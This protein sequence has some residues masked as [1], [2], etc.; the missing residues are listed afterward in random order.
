MLVPASPLRFFS[1]HTRRHTRSTAGAPPRESGADRHA[2]AHER[3]TA[4]RRLATSALA[5]RATW[6]TLTAAVLATTVLATPGNCYAEEDS[7]PS[8]LGYALEGF[9]TGIAVGFASGYLA[10]GPKFEGGEWRTLLWGGGIGALSGLGIGLILGI[11]DASTVPNGRGVGFYI[12]R[13]SNYG[14]SVGALAGGVI[15]ALIWAGGGVA[16]DLLLGLAW[17]TV[18]GAGAG[19]IMG[20][21]EGSLRSGRGSKAERRSTFQVGLGFTPALEG[22]APMTYPTLSGRF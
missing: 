17:G 6:L 16:K 2:E 14:Y 20:V 15:G 9:G 19:V 18:I 8:I 7:T 3:P 22:G 1:V 4:S 10:T 12:M 13:D 5:R 21:I 11:V